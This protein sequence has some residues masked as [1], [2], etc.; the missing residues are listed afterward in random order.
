MSFKSVCWIARGVD[1]GYPLWSTLSVPSAPGCHWVCRVGVLGRD[2]TLGHLPRAGQ[3]ALAVATAAGCLQGRGVSLSE[4][5]SPYVNH[6]TTKPLYSVWRLVCDG[7]TGRVWEMDS[8]R[9]RCKYMGC[10]ISRYASD[11][12]VKLSSSPGDWMSLYVRSLLFTKLVYM[13]H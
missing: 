1:D 8:S 7:M 10:L 4:W 2:G 11:W 9:V 6:P 5:Q 3:S 12:H 13:E